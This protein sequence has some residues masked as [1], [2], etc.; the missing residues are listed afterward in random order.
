MQIGLFNLSRGF[1]LGFFFF[2]FATQ[3]FANS[4]NPDL[5]EAKQIMRP[6]IERAWFAGQ[7]EEK[8]FSAINQMEISFLPGNFCFKGQSECLAFCR[9]QLPSGM[10]DGLLFL[11]KKVNGK[12]ADGRWFETGILESKPGNADNDSL[13]DL[14]IQTEV[15]GSE[16]HQGMVKVVS[17]KGGRAKILYQASTWDKSKTDLKA[18][19][20]G[21]KVAGRVSLY[22]AD[23]NQDGKNEIVEII[24]SAFVVEKETDKTKTIQ[25]SKQKNIKSYNNHQFQQ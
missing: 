13:V 12:W 1:L 14:I 15:P 3:S 2:L 17:L 20:V 22:L 10:K 7:P 18:V 25:W 6:V 19:P 5:G 23:T 24:E 16:D 9:I 21:Q 11:F 8:V 4:S